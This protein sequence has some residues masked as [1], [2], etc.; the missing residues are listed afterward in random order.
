VIAAVNV[1]VHAAETSVDTLLDDHLP[2][3]LRTA[4]DISHDWSLTATVPSITA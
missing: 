1:T 2:K 3:L 4:A